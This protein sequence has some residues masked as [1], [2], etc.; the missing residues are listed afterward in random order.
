M[1][2]LTDTVESLKQQ[3]A[4]VQESLGLARA[5]AQEAY[6]QVEQLQDQVA[7]LSANASRY[8]WL[9]N[10]KYL[11]VAPGNEYNHDWQVKFIV[12]G[13]WSDLADPRVL[14]SLLDLEI[15][16]AKDAK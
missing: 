11:P 13:I 3:L 15:K 14:D 4:D 7:N 8:L 12:R 9:R 10:N 2:D 16:K 1:A 6:S 5:E